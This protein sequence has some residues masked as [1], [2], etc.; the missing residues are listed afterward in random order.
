MPKVLKKCPDSSAT[1]AEKIK[2][3]TIRKEE[4]LKQMKN[5]VHRITD[6]AVKHLKIRRRV[7]F[8]DVPS[9]CWFPKTQTVTLL[10]PKKREGK[11]KS[12]LKKKIESIK[13]K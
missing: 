11:L 1:E 12:C 13:D 5:A 2:H 8:N 3:T 6:L 7:T 9:V 10:T 4:K